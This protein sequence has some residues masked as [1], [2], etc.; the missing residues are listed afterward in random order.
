MKKILLF[1]ML[2]VV[3]FFG[4]SFFVSQEEK[5]EKFE[6]TDNNEVIYGDKED[7]VFSFNE[8]TIPNEKIVAFDNTNADYIKYFVVEFFD[9]QFIS[10]SYHFLKNHEQ[11]LQVYEEL[12][13]NVVD[14]NYEEFML[15]TLDDI[16]YA[17]YDEFIY[18][19]QE[20]IDNNSIYIIY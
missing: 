2:F 10:Y 16:S 11:Y 7:Y 4:V 6:K 14:Y 18:N 17:T 1:L 9:E 13:P 15:K 12:I 8:K 5:N 20:L 19:I 3:T